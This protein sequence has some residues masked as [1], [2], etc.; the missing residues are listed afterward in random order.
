MGIVLVIWIG[1]LNVNNGSIHVGEIIAFTNYMTQILFS[2]MMITNV[3]TMFVRAKASSER[4]SEIFSEK[5]TMP[6]IEKTVENGF[7]TGT[8]EFKNVFFTYNKD[9]E[10]VLN[11]ISFTCSC[12]ETIGIIGS[13]GS[14]KSTLVNFIP[15][16]Y[17]T[18]KGSVVVDGINVKAM[19]MT[20]LREKL[21]LVP[22]KSLLF[23]GTIL[24]NIKW[25]NENASFEEIE[26]AA[27]IAQAHD[28]IKSFR[29]ATMQ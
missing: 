6:D 16:F 5:S 29:M 23:S 21:S 26:K 9:K 7:G 11:D 19:N 20:A 15:R 24:D 12:G 10:P 28:F 1:G 13:T 8:I 14:G 17:D 2:L 22:Q 25:G 3:F 4:I 27:Q 18:L